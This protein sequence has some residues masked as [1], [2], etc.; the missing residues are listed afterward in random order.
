ME[1][2]SLFDEWEGIESQTCHVGFTQQQEEDLKKEM[3]LAIIDFYRKE[4][5]DHDQRTGA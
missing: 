5:G 1:Q 4:S 2:L 3:A